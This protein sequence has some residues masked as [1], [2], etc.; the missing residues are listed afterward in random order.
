MPATI[1]ERFSEW[2]EKRTRM[3]QWRKGTTTVRLFFELTPYVYSRPKGGQERKVTHEQAAR[4]AVVELDATT[5]VEE[6][7][8]GNR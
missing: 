8:R 2:E 1:P 3:H 6:E 4:V 5:A 7:K